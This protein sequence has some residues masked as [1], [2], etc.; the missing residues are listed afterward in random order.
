MFGGSTLDVKNMHCFSFVMMYGLSSY[1]VLYST[2][3]N[4]FML[5][6][7]CYIFSALSNDFLSWIDFY[8]YPIFHWVSIGKNGTIQSQKRESRLYKWSSIE[9][10]FKPSHYTM[11]HGVVDQP[12]LPDDNHWLLGMLQ[13]V[14]FLSQAECL[15]WF[16]LRT[17]W[18]DRSTLT[19]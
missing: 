11:N 10:G 13:Q 1:N 12:L 3:N 19:Q 5:T 14:C 2:S 16:E 8:F 18:F 9:R 17:F 7:T 15:V 6:K 4:F